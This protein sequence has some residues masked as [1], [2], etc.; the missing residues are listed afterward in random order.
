MLRKLNASTASMT[1]SK[2]GKEIF[3]LAG[4]SLSK[5]NASSGEQTPI[6]FSAVVEID[7]HKE[8]EHLFEHVWRQTKRK[9]YRP[10][11]HGVDWQFYREQYKPKLAGVKSN[12]VFA[13][14]L[15]EILGELNA[16]HTGGRY[17]P[18]P[19][20][21]NANTAALGVFYDN[22]YEGPGRRIAEIMEGGPLDRSELDIEAGMIITHIDGV[23]LT[24][25]TN[26]YAQLDGKAGDRVRLTLQRENGES[27]DEVVRPVSLGAE[28]NLRYERWVRTRRELVDELSD[29]RLAYMHVRGM[30]DPS[31]R[32]FYREVLGRHY[33]REALIVDTRFNGGGW[34]HDDLITFLTGERYVD[35]YPR[36]DESPNV[37]YVGDTQWRWTKPSIVVMSEGNYSDAHFFPWAYTVLGVGD[38][39]GMPVPGTATAVWW[40][41]LHTGDLV[42]GIPQ[43]GTK[44]MD[45]EYLENQQLEPTHEVP[46]PPEDAA[47]GRDTQIIEAVRIMLEKLEND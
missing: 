44:G 10:D 27:F 46:L 31:F 13:E 14:L 7:G 25:T 35:F 24:A 43:V 34:L 41:R 26:F 12:R 19:Q 21:G 17:F 32:V 36:D 39:V 16:S 20:D 38:T 11:L 5:I 18:P 23:E 29:G 6:A 1:L 42:F 28:N 2:D 3:L 40:E 45:G 9:F 8:R 47:S 15:S 30:N 4:G 22:D 37:S 33:D